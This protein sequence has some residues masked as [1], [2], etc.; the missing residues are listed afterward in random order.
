MTNKFKKTAINAAKKTGLLLK[1]NIGKAHHIEFKGAIDIVTEMDKRAE[2]LIIKIIKHEF[3]EHGILTEESP[4]QKTDS[5]YR[6]IIDPLDGTT[7]YSHG[8]PVFCVS[9]ALEKRGEIILGVVYNPMLNELFTARIGQGAYLNNKK[10]KIS[11]IGELS[12]SLLATGFPY[13]VRTSP[14]NNITH[15]ANF[16]VRA[17]AIR[18]AGSAALDMCYVACGRFD[19]FWELKLKPWDTAAATLI[20]KEAGGTATDFGGKPF[21]LYTGET[22]ASNGLIH[23]EMIK[24]LQGKEK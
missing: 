6:W 12:R 2:E 7:N 15:F 14:Q 17:Q 11:N 18:R 5:E 22:L 19:G 13:D 20:I 3:P 24:V 1:K 4:E 10:I 16:A 9:I 23:N 21:S 8:F